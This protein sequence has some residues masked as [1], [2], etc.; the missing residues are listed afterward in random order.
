[1]IA[2]A[3]RNIS[4]Y[5]IYRAASDAMAWLPIFF[6]FFSERLSL[7]EVLLLEAIYYIAVVITEVPSGYLSDLV[8][9]RRTLL[10]S[11]LAILAAYVCFLY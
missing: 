7:P 3:E 6:L 9:R 2:S 1:M 11:C 10:L 4:L 5:P 8:G